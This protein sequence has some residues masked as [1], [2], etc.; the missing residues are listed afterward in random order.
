VIGYAA[1]YFVWVT[2]LAACVWTRA[3]PVVPVG[4][5]HLYVWHPDAVCHVHPDTAGAW[6]SLYRK[7]S[8]LTLVGGYG[9]GALLLKLQ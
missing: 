6:R 4:S 5:R 3:S 1:V 9:L 2:L 8:I 7:L